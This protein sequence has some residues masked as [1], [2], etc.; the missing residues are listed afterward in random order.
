M[1]TGEKIRFLA[2]FF[3]QIYILVFENLSLVKYKATFSH[4]HR[5]SE[6]VIQELLIIKVPLS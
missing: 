3:L 2:V 5:A 6:S 4:T 1:V